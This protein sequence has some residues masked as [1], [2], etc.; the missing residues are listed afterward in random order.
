VRLSK[1]CDDLEAKDGTWHPE[2]VDCIERMEKILIGSMEEVNPTVVY[3][4][5]SASAAARRTKK[6]VASDL[7]SSEITKEEERRSKLVSGIR[8]EERLLEST[9]NLASERI[10]KKEISQVWKTKRSIM[11]ALRTRSFFD[12]KGILRWQQQEVLDLVRSESKKL[13]EPEAKYNVG[14][15]NRSHLEAILTRHRIIKKA[16]M[17]SRDWKVSEDDVT[18]IV[19]YIYSVYKKRGAAGGSGLEAEM[20]VMAG[21]AILRAIRLCLRLIQHCGRIPHHWKIL[22]IIL[23]LKPGRPQHELSSYRPIG[24]AEI[25]M[26]AVEKVIGRRYEKLLLLNPIHYAIMAYSK[27]KSTGMAMFIIT[28]SHLHMR[29]TGVRSVTVVT[30]VKYA[31]N[32]TNRKV[33]VLEWDHLGLRGQIWELSRQLSGDTTY[34]TRYLGY[35]TRPATQTVGYTQGKVNSPVKFNISMH[36]MMVDLEDAGVG[37]IVHKLCGWI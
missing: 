29:M 3:G 37:I 14:S 24:L 5:K 18:T 35:K 17:S 32:G 1:W 23:A 20:V 28:E 11:G 16:A 25:I 7:L 6:N 4:E 31:Y 19:E 33:E 8:E 12:D 36:P 34:Q 13:C 30:D 9:A 26:K 10:E 22:L 27:G 21:S 2:E 15:P